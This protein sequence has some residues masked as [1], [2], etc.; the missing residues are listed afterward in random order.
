MKANRDRLKIDAQRR[1]NTFVLTFVPPRV[2]HSVLFIKRN[3]TQCKEAKSR[4]VI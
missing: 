2:K 4:P 3:L 1:L